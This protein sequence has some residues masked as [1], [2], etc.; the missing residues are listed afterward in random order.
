MRIVQACLP[1]CLLLSVQISLALAERPLAAGIWCNR[2]KSNR[3]SDAHFVV[4]A[5]NNG[6]EKLRNKRKMTKQTKISDFSFVSYS[7][8]PPISQTT[9]NCGVSLT[10]IHS[11]RLF[12]RLR[13]QAQA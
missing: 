10:V 11:S 3:V 6:E 9:V 5:F 7:P 13:Q 12:L 8:L 4:R 2:E 1:G